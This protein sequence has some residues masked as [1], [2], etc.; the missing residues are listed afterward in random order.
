MPIQKE[1]PE[2]ELLLE[3]ALLCS[4]AQYGDNMEV[5]GSPMECAILRAATEC[6]MDAVNIRGRNR[7]IREIPFDSTR[8]RMNSVHKALDGSCFEI[9]K[10][11]FD[12]LLPLCTE[13]KSAGKNVPM[14]RRMKEQLIKLHGEMAGQALRVL[15]V[16][17]KEKCTSAGQAESGFCFLGLIGFLDPPREESLEA[18]KLCKSAGIRP[19][20][21]TG[22][23]ALTAGAIARKLG[24]ASDGRV[25]TGTEL[26]QMT[27]REL[28]DA[29]R[30]CSVFARVSPEHKVRIVKAFQ[31]NGEVVAMTGDG[32]NDAPVLAGADVGAAMGNGSDAAIEA[33]DVVF[34]T[35]SVSAIPEAVDIARKTKA[36][37]LQNVVFALLVKG[38]VMLLGLAGFASMWMAVFADTGVT[39]ITIFNTLRLKNRFRKNYKKDY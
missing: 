35:S 3:S 30:H 13:Y 6:G 10:G 25:I 36:I 4:N 2:R 22:D 18:V 5:Y 28:K 20:M 23:H 31:A 38:L 17:C 19:V 7:R 24:I 21:V 9:I 34:M 32:I 14:D 16:V 1:L 8:K 27:D 33:A 15:A 29:V 26:Q 39:V 12:Y 11:A 37:A